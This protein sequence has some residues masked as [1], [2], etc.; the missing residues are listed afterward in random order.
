M[1]QEVVNKI[2]E[3]KELSGLDDSVVE[4]VVQ[5]K[6]KNISMKIEDM[7]EKQLKELVKMSRA[8]L[9]FLIGGFKKTSNPEEVDF[10]ETE[11]KDLL[12]LHSSTRERLDFYPKLKEMIAAM[13]IKSILDLGCGLNPL[14]LANKS[15]KYYAFDI[16]RDDIN[17]VNKFFIYNADRWNCFS[18]RSKGSGQ[19]SS[20]NCR[21]VYYIKGLRRYRKERT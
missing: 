14:A 16:N 13:K 3:K 4:K 12:S 8:E 15:Y 17:L 20:P 21:P 6:L 18:V 19:P 9:R 5:K 1:M 2:K 7:R 10:S 11:I